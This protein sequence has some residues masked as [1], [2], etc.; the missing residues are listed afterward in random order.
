M[1][2]N[3]PTDILDWLR[4][5]SRANIPSVKHFLEEGDRISKFARTTD[6]YWEIDDVDIF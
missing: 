2:V 3:N 5:V 1:T 4:R 6:D